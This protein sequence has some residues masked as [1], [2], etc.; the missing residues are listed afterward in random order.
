M[1]EEIVKKS[2]LNR[3]IIFTVI[4]T[5][6]LAYFLV[7]ILIERNTEHIELAT[8]IS[9]TVFFI[10]GLIAFELAYKKDSER[11]ALNGLELMVLAAHAMSI[12]HVI[13]RYDFSLIAYLTTSQFIMATYFLIKA[14]AI[15]TKGKKDYLDSLSDIKT[16]A[17]KEELKIKKATKRGGKK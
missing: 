11:I 14:V 17:K 9:A 4:A 13:T 2:V 12:M 16:I 8:R 10:A 6:I 5:G 7:L 3:V 15:Y 1:D